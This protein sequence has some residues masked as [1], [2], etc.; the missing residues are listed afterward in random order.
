MTFQDAYAADPGPRGC[1]DSRTEDGVYLELGL[2]PFGMPLEHFLVDPP[3]PWDPELP[4]PAQGV[5]AIKRNGVWHIVDRVGREYYPN[6]ADF[7]EEVRRMGLSRRVP[8]N[9]SAVDPETGATVGFE[10]ITEETRILLVHDRAIIKNSPAFIEAADRTAWECPKQIIEHHWTHPRVSSE[11]ATCCAGC[12]WSNLT[13]GIEPSDP[14]QPTSR[15]V[16]RTMPGFEY[17]GMRP[18]EGVTAEYGGPALFL[19]LPISRIA[20]VNGERAG[21]RLERVAAAHLPTGIV[22]R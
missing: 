19:S 14:T 3:Q 9:F 6:P 11:P 1:G 4:L 17:F 7:Y 16:T 18:P 21:E 22:E 15:N 12:W 13:E 8:H 20:V 10:A 5:G 2:S